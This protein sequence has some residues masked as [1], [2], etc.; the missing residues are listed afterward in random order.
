MS[1][2]LQLLS[3]WLVASLAHLFALPKEET[4]NPTAFIP[5]IKHVFNAKPESF[6]AQIPYRILVMGWLFPIG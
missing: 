4:I 1:R 3:Y 2:K 5:P 6:R